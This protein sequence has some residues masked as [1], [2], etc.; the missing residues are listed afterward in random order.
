MMTTAATSILEE[1]RALTAAEK[2]RLAEHDKRDRELV[3][4]ARKAGATWD[5]IAKAK[6]VSRAAVQKRY[7]P[8]EDVVAIRE[9]DE[10]PGI[11]VSDYATKMN[12]SERTVRN[13][14]SDG[15]VKA[16][17]VPSTNNGRVFH[18][19]IE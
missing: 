4:S 1:L 2:R 9:M 3:D 12:T 18:R 7:N 5:E 6:G 15:R 8:V 16:I 11:S 13:M 19:I 14:I 10:L 17:Q